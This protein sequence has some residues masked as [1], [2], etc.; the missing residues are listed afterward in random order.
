MSRK[1]ILLAAVMAAVSAALLLVG[2]APASARTDAEFWIGSPVDGHWASSS[3]CPASFP[4]RRCAD[5][6]YHAVEYSS[7]AGT[8]RDRT[9]AVDLGGS[10]LDEG[11]GVYL[12][13][14]PYGAGVSLTTKV[15]GLGPAC[16][17]GTGRAGRVVVIGVYHGSR[18]VGTVAYAYVKPTVVLGQIVDPHGTRIGTLATAAAP[19][20]CWDHLHLHVE[21]GNTNNYSCFSADL[22]TGRPWGDAVRRTEFMGWVGGRRATDSRQACPS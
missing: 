19:G 20:S 9:W 18:R 17:P 11:T 12:Y 14:T 21:A 5:P 1:V 2:V 16:A 15:D 6:R 4:S 3:G 13:L 8:S 22:H 7:L 10:P